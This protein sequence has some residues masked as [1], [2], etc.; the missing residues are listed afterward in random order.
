MI[1]TVIQQRLAGLA[2]GRVYGGVAPNALLQFHMAGDVHGLFGSVR[3]VAYDAGARS[4]RLTL[5]VSRASDA[6]GAPAGGFARP[7]LTLLNNLKAP[8][9]GSSFAVAAALL[10]VLGLAC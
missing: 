6:L 1:E 7:V 8:A 3:D 5:H 2:G 10:I 9:E 4:L